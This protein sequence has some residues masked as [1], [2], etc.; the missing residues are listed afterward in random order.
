MTSGPS[1]PADFEEFKS[2]LAFFDG[3]AGYNP[4]SRSLTGPAEPE[5][6]RVVAVDANWFP[7]LGVQPVLGRAFL[8]EE[9]RPGG[10]R[11]A[12][13]SHDLWQRRYGAQRDLA[14]LDVRLDGEAYRVVGVLPAGYRFTGPPSDIHVARNTKGPVQA[15]GRLKHGVPQARID[16]DLAAQ[17]RAIDARAPRHKDWALTLA[18]VRDW[19]DSDARLSL[20]V[21]EVAVLLVLLIACFNVAGLLTLRAAARGRD[22]AVMLSLGAGRGHIFGHFLSEILPL[23]VGGA[24]GGLGLA[25]VLVRLLRLFP[26]DR[27]PRL[28]EVRL[29]PVALAV[30]AGASLIV[31]LLCALLPMFSVR[32]LG[33][34]ETLRQSGRSGAPGPAG[35][36]LR[37]VLVSAEVGLAL[38]LTLGAVMMARTVASMAATNPGFRASGVLTASIELPRAR[39]KEAAQIGG[40]FDQW[41]E[42]LRALPGV[43]SATYT[44]SLPLGGNYMMAD[45]SAEGGA[46]AGPDG[47]QAL[48]FRTVSRD[49][50]NT[51]GLRLMKG[52]FFD[53]GDRFG[54]ELVMVVN[55]SAARRLFG[56]EE[57]LGRRA[58]FPKEMFT[59]V[60]VVGDSRHEDITDSGRPEILLSVEQ[61]PALSASVAV[62]LNPARYEDPESFAPMLRGVLASVDPAVAAYRIQSLDRIAGDRLSPRRLNLL[63]LG[64]FATLAL[65]LAA[66]GIYGVLA[67]SVERRT[68]EIG[69]RRA[70]GARPAHLLAM[71][72]RQALL[73]AG[74]GIAAGLAG[75]R[76]LL[77][78]ARS[79]LYGVQPGDPAW[80]AAAALLLLAVALAAAV[81]PARRAL[82]IDPAEA[83]R[84]Q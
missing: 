11:V 67:F 78:A 76:F 69:V 2:T 68:Q 24:A 39:Y 52:R 82:R 7:L 79:L 6:V 53:G 27:I 49:Y 36:R 9:A 8:P 77:R 80:Q 28:A 3:V 54:S 37:A 62:R 4:S 70:L 47:A 84:C 33:L 38:M 18:P 10:D 19:V 56:D 21:L 34:D 57:P 43:E 73:L 72:L 83:L 16:A 71:I 35:S 17:D 12:I 42:R 61:K 50:L 15:L 30:T 23:A 48:A 20:L 64:C 60:G 13:L 41:L 32:R 31:C 65:A 66:S 1:S 44:N 75:A 55:Q 26:T 58:G 46:A 45:F 25:A 29:E 14:D 5:R 74:I 63:L 22:V 81:I 59:V 40:F 51:L